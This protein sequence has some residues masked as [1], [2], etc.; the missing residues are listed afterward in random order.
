MPLY[1]LFVVEEKNL[2]WKHIHKSLPFVCM[3]ILGKNVRHLHKQLPWLVLGSTQRVP[4]AQALYLVWG[5]S[6][7]FGSEPLQT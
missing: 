6:P 4:L 7:S 3:D 1:S 2:S 5:S